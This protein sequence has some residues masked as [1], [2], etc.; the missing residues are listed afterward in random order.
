LKETKYE[1]NYPHYKQNKN[2]IRGVIKKTSS[3]TENN[4]AHH[5][6]QISEWLL[7]DLVQT[8]PLNPTQCNKSH[9]IPCCQVQEQDEGLII[10]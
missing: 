6:H 1:L 10:E 5:A 8:H 2:G 7:V 3:A 9:G 4:I